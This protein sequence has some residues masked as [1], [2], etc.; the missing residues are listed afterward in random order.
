MRICTKCLVEK[1]LSEFSVFKRD[2]R[3]TR[4]RDC[5][6]AKTRAWHHANRERQNAIRVARSKAN[7]ERENARKR[8]W[9]RA[10]PE[11]KRVYHERYALKD[12]ERY[13]A[14]VA[15]AN[16]RRRATRGGVSAS[17]WARIRQ[18]FGSLCAYCGRRPARLTQDHLVPLATGGL[19]EPDNV[20]PACSF[21]NA[22]KGSRS[23]LVWV[24][25]YGMP[26]GAA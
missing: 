23:V 18:E 21:C 1:P 2:G 5:L 16:H 14:N 13:R 4:C 19:H 26:H 24:A 10:N 7:R 25:S 8:E 3:M 22:S 6:N 17:Q 9:M 11:K 15:N 12:T 20:V